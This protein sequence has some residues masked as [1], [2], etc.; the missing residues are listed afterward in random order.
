V[1]G[2]KDYFDFLDTIEEAIESIDENK[3][4]LCMKIRRAEPNRLAWECNTCGRLYLDDK[5]GNL[6]EYLPQN[7]KANR[8]FDR[9]R[10]EHKEQS[11]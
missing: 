3:E 1:I 2:D 8:I 5:D 6:V 11:D 10:L 7:G 4:S 9:A